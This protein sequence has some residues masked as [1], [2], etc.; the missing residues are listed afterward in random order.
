M[1]RPLVTRF[2]MLGWKYA[3]LYAAAIPNLHAVDVIDATTNSSTRKYKRIP[4]NLRLPSARNARPRAHHTNRADHRHWHFH[5]QC[6]EQAHSK[7]SNHPLFK[8]SP[9]TSPTP[10]PSHSPHP[11]PPPQQSSPLPPSPPPP[12]HQPSSSPPE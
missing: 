4:S 3:S 5:R 2:Y 6:V 11:R 9:P 7:I 12:K 1:T 8:K 10:S